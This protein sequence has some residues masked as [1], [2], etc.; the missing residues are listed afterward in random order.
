MDHRFFLTAATLP[1][2]AGCESGDTCSF[3][4]CDISGPQGG[5]NLM[6]IDENNALPALREAWFAATATAELPLFFVATGVGNTIGSTATAGGG[7]SKIVVF[8]DPSGPTVYNCPVSGT[9][10]VSGDVADPNTVTAGDFVTFESSACDS[11]TG[12]TVDGAHSLNIASIAG[13]IAAGQF[14]QA[15]TLAFTDFRAAS[16]TL[17]TTLNGD[18]TAVID[19]LVANTVT[20]AFSGN[21]L[22]INED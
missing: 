8:V 15:Q 7:A 3:G 1:L 12:Y 9:F 22:E 16:P 10:M 21:S 11:G 19:T 4:G 17:V 6:T 2:V 14:E 13:D 18:H 5:S 20:T